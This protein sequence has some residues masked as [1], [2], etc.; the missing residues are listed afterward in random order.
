MRRV[1]QIIRILIMIMI[2]YLI[3]I[4]GRGCYWY[5]KSGGENVSIV[6]STQYSPV[7]SSV[8]VYIDNQLYFKNDSLQ[9]LYE[10]VH[11]PLSCGI[12][13]LKVIIDQEVFEE[14]FY[15]FPVRWIY[16]EI[17]KDDVSN[18]KENNDWLNIAFSSSPLGLM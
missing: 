6:L 12:H 3:C 13:H 14:N 11:L 1:K 15:V 16:I 2:F 5:H 8:S 18:Y 10:W 9:V 4:L 7:S 17:Q